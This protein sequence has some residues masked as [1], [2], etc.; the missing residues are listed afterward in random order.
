[1]VI[2]IVESNSVAKL[3]PSTPQKQHSCNYE[4]NIIIDQVLERVGD[5]GRGGVYEVKI[6]P[7]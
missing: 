5:T 7:I 3:N 2:K 4:V 6:M 1:M